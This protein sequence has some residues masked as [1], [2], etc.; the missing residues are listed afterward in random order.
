LSWS[1][2]KDSALALHALRDSVE[3]EVTALITSVTN[4]YDRI[5]IHGVRRGLLE[6]QADALGLPLVEVTLEPACSDAAYQEA[7]LRGL[8]E[9][10]R[11]QPGIAHV[12]FGDLYLA[13]VRA[14]R[15]RLLASTRFRGLYPLWQQPTR[16]LAE[17]FI[18]AG[19]VATLVCT[20]NTQIDPSFAGRPFDRALLADLPSTADPCGENGEF[21]T[22][23]SGGPGFREPVAWVKGETVTRDGRFTYCDLVGVERPV[24]SSR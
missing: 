20:D 21:H 24:A 6:R 1:G 13:D 15:D 3:Y 14:Y 12:A 9:L 7:F 4:G 23:V 16:E 8:A 22:F 19:F 10:G 17:R 5:S 11:L 2:G 18:S